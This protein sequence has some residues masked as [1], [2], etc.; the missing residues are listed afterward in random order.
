MKNRSTL[1]LMEMLVMLLVF[2]L[3]SAVCLQIFVAAD[4][5]SRRTQQ[6]DHAVLLAQNG[7]ELLKSQK[8]DLAQT[9][10]KLGGTTDGKTVTVREAALLME[11]T[12]L[13]EEIPGLEQALIQ[14]KEGETV[15][16]SL[17]AGWQKE[18][19]Q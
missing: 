14:V 2:A 3:A 6:Q 15:L 8:G 11:I 10:E 17:T 1:V 18:V 19:R 9:A 4:R 12:L 16:F 5:V 7:A 13:P